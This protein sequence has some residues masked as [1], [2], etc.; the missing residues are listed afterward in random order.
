MA[1]VFSAIT[2]LSICI[3]CCIY[4]NNQNNPRTGAVTTVA[5]PRVVRVQVRPTG[6]NYATMRPPVPAAVHTVVETAPPPYDAVVS[7]KDQYPKY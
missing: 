2:L 1:I 5:N 4:C 6:P 7:A 3:R